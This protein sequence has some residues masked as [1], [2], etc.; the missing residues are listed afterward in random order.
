MI[1]IIAR[2]VVREEC[3]EQ[4]RALARELVEKSRREAGCI[5]YQSLQG[6]T[7]RRIH[8]FVEEWKDQAAI[9]AHNA[10]EHFTRIVPQLGELFAGE[11]IVDGGYL[12]D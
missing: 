6:L 3:I 1:K 7:D 9:E 2:Q 11:E 10:S 8:I 5:H 4:Y 12:G